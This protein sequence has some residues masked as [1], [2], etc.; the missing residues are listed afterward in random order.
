VSRRSWVWIAL[1]GFLLVSVGVIWRRTVGHAEA[2]KL[3]ELTRRR[4]ALRPE[5]LKLE[6]EIRQASS[7]AQLAPLAER[8]LGM[9]VPSATQV[10]LLKRPPRQNDSQ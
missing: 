3:Q 7:R 9:R 1:A 8:R 6:G 5:Q 4:D 10:I 2:R